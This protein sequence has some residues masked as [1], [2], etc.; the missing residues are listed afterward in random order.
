MCMHRTIIISS[1]RN[2]CIE[3]V[4][5]EMCMH[6]TM[7]ISSCRNVCAQNCDIFNYSYNNVA[8]L[9]VFTAV[10]LRIPV[11]W[12]VMLCQPVSGFQHFEVSYCLQFHGHNPRSI[13]NCLTPEYEGTA[14][15]AGEYIT[16]F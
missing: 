10:L 3:L 7:I 5:A 11:I 13:K 9:E 1:C 8:R 4:H 2:V 14:L 15:S 12:D 16:V 6:R